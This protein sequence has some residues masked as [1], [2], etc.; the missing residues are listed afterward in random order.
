MAALPK[1]F[2]VFFRK[3]ELRLKHIT[4]AKDEQTAEARIVRAYAPKT[5]VVIDVREV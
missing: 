4:Q 2:E 3:G 5:V 1:R